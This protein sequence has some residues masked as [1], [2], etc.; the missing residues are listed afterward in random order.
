MIPGTI[1]HPSGRA[2]TMTLWYPEREYTSVKLPHDRMVPG[3]TTYPSGR[4]TRWPIDTR[5]QHT[6][7]KPHLISGRHPVIG[8]TEWQR[9]ASIPAYTRISL[10]SGSNLGWRVHIRTHANW[11]QISLL[12]SLTPPGYFSNSTGSYVFISLDFSHVWLV[13]T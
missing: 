5:M 10:H 8:H 6:P 4:A 9:Y 1:T 3:N 13:G 12:P 7:A 2:T 11:S